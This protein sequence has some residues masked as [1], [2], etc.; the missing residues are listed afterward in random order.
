MLIWG[1]LKM[2]DRHQTKQHSHSQCR[3]FTL[4]VIPLLVFQC[5]ADSKCEHS[6][7]QKEYIIKVSF[8]TE[9]N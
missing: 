5:T 2:A 4:V 6:G 7:H 9:M 1:T 8:N 3:E